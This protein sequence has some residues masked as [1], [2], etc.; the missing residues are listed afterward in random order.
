MSVIFRDNQPQGYFPRG[1]NWFHEIP[2]LP[3]GWETTNDHGSG[4]LKHAAMKALLKDQ[5]QLKPELFEIVPWHLAKYLW[6]ALGRWWVLV[7]LQASLGPI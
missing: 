3:H 1:E 2:F 7:P 6:D 4:S 5:S